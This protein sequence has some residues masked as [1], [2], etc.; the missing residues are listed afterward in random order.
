[1]KMAELMSDHAP[2]V[3]RAIAA[4]S[5]NMIVQYKE[6]LGKSQAFQ[7]KILANIGDVI[8]I[9][10]PNGINKFKSPNIE[11][12]FG[13]KPEEVIGRSAIENVH[14]DD[15]SGVRKFMRGLVEEPNVSR[16]AECRYRCKDGGYKWIE[17]TGIN[18]I[19]DPDIRG[20]LGNYRDITE[21]KRIEDLLRENE[22][23]Y[24]ILYD[25]INDA[26]FTAEVNED[27]S[28]GNFI[29]VNDAACQQLGY[30]R[31]ELLLKKPADIIPFN[32]R[33]L[34]GSIISKI[35]DKKRMISESCHV[36]KDGKIIPV[37]I[38]ANFSRFKNKT[39]V[40]AIARDITERDLAQRKVRES[41]KRFKA[42]M[43]QSPI[44]IALLDILGHPLVTNSAL[45]KMVG[46]SSEELSLMTFAE[47]THAEDVEKD[48]DLFNSLLDG[49]I[50]DYR[51]E[52]RYIHKDGSVVWGNI[53]VTIRRDENGNPVEII[54]M[55]GDITELKKKEENLRYI[56]TRLRQSEKMEAIGQLAGGI[57]HDFNNVLGGIIGFTDMSLGY[58]DKG[59][60]QENFLFKVLKA[61]ERAKNL[62]KQILAFSRQGNPQKAHI[63]I[64]PI[65]TEVVDL[66]K[67]S[68]PSSVTIKSDLHADTRLV[69]ADSTQIHQALLNLATNAVYAMNHHGI[70][71]IRLYGT[72][73]HSM[74]YGQGGVIMPGEY[75]VIEVVDTG[76]G[77]DAKILAKAFEP[78]FTT[79]PVGEGT[80]MG[81]SVVFGIVQSID[82]DLQVES[83]VGKGTTVRMFL[84]A[85]EA[86]A[87]TAPADHVQASLYGTERILFVDDEEILVDMNLNILTSLGYTVTATNNSGDVLRLIRE[88]I[89]DI[90]ILITD[91]TMPGIT[92]IELAKE[93]LL[94]RKD[95]PVILCTGFSNDVDRESAMALGISKFIM[96]PYRSHEISKAI[97]EVLDAKKVDM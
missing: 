77:M 50:S 83:E 42:I 9:I 55:V 3:H 47:F 54:G 12:L 31:E 13:W 34:G 71:S 46:Y 10:D 72:N 4:T 18:L 16:S 67:S 27:G 65:V 91:Q 30:T 97:R 94:M 63:A 62:V 1:M 39:V 81:L 90:D 37:E 25:N 80:G 75:T 73:L 40:H 20:I 82:G 43:E 17:F 11:K 57:A 2:N 93:A 14:P 41:E 6:A 28:V 22:E 23:A 61:S 56:E 8:V 64:R 49:T 87:T 79:K 53:F 33:P 32:L 59:S 70:L 89:A 45:S 48:V 26:F 76:C 35:G 88:K 96:K 36:T 21:R 85:A 60:I 15:L 38:S 78:F 95:L 7:S 69:L 52:K 19:G 86:S 58:A 24:R 51:M 68:I 29:L 92:G 74:V 44:G 5:E 66:L 84:P